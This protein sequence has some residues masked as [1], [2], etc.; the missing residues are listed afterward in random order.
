MIDKALPVILRFMRAKGISYLYPDESLVLAKKILRNSYLRTGLPVHLDEDLNNL[1]PCRGISSESYYLRHQFYG[2]APAQPLASGPRTTLEYKFDDNG[3]FRLMPAYQSTHGGHCAICFAVVW[4]DGYQVDRSRG[5]EYVF[6]RS[7]E[8]RDFCD[9]IANYMSH[10]S[11]LKPYKTV[12]NAFAK[13]VNRVGMF[14]ARTSKGIDWQSATA[15]FLDFSAR[16]KKKERA[17]TA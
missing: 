8:N 4:D 14:R 12:D 13:K 15:L 3:V 11:R 10:A 1:E 17:M 2:N 16:V 7:C 6:G 9:D 5:E